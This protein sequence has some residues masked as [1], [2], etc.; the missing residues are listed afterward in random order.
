MT[1]VTLIIPVVIYPCGRVLAVSCLVDK[2]IS[3]HSL[4]IIQIF[5][6]LCAY[7]FFLIILVITYTVLLLSLIN[8]DCER[9]ITIFF[10]RTNVPV[11]AGLL[12]EIM[13]ND[14]NYHSCNRNVCSFYKRRHVYRDFQ[15]KMKNVEH[16]TSLPLMQVSY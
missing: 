9:L 6:R 4:F 13:W 15:S 16:V 11:A 7:E 12:V 2:I 14:N 5:I 1:F 10:Y 8:V 3:F